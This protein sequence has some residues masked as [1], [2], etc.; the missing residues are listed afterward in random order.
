MLI[1]NIASIFNTIVIRLRS[2]MVPTFIIFTSFLY[3]QRCTAPKDWSGYTTCLSKILYSK[4][5]RF[6]FCCRGWDSL[7]LHGWDTLINA[8]SLKS[9]LLKN[10]LL[11][12]S[13]LVLKTVFFKEYFIF[14][15]GSQNTFE[16]YITGFL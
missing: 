14:F 16:Q 2:M 10:C 3:K 6:F 15:I 5:L 12:G 1:V 7:L 4:L 8:D 9:C 11:S 13:K